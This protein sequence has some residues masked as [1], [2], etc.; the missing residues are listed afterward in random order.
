MHSR[1]ARST[2]QS[3]GHTGWP[4]NRRRWRSCLRLQ[5]NAYKGI[6]ERPLGQC[7]NASGTKQQHISKDFS[8]T[9]YHLMNV[10]CSSFFDKTSMF[11]SEKN[12]QIIQIFMVIIA[13]KYTVWYTWK[14]WWENQISYLSIRYVII[15]DRLLFSFSAIFFNLL[16]VSFGIVMFNLMYAMTIWYIVNTYWCNT[17]WIQLNTVFNMHY[18]GGETWE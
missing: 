12:D 18:F 6:K 16:T 13:C 3:P 2:S 10:I 5:G 7:L 15:F 14:N 1:S 8:K 9:A 4:D 17:Y 11:Y